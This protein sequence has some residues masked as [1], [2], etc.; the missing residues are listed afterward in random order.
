MREIISTLPFTLQFNRNLKPEDWKDMDQ[1]LKLHQLLKHLFQWSI[2]KKTFNLA[3]HWAELGAN[4]QKICLKEIDFKKV[5]VITKGLNPTRKFR[6]LEARE[7]RIRENQATI[8]AIEEQIN[9]TMPSLIPSVSQVVDKPTL[10]WLPPFRH[11]KISGQASP[12]FTIQ[13]SFQKETRKQ[14]EKNNTSFNQRQR[15]SEPVIQKL[16]GWVKEVHR[17]QK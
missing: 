12:F 11:Q 16:L 7:T 5:M 2:D 1:V 10:W 13:G 17:S 14:R 3:T 6:L 8:Q 4:C 15:E 9:K